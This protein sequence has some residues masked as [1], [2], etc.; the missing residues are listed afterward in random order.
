MDDRTAEASGE[1]PDTGYIAAYGVMIVPP[2]DR[3]NGGW[4]VTLTAWS[5][6]VET[7][8]ASMDGPIFETREEAFEEAGKVL[9]WIADKGDRDD[10]MRIWEQ[11]QR[12]VRR[13][14]LEEGEPR[15]LGRWW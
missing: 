1:S 2:S 9:D 8:A 11:M 14:A 12:D 13:E 6:Q 15:T 5:D 3:E 7:Y 10:L 4:M